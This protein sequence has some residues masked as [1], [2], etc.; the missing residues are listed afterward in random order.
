M[1]SALGARLLEGGAQIVTTLA[2]RSART[3]RLARE[4]GIE[5]LDDLDAVVREAGVVLSVAP[6]DQA[7]AI[8]GVVASAATRTGSSPLVADLN[9]ISPATA[10]GIEASLRAAGLDLVDGS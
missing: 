1:G 2:G 6:P 7:E 3:A 8:A 5:C 10:R 9:A 4:A